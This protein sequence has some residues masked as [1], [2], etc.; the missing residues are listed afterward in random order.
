ME[1]KI[2]CIEDVE[3]EIKESREWTDKHN[4]GTIAEVRRILC[5]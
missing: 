2:R 1:E 3:R 4:K 5:V